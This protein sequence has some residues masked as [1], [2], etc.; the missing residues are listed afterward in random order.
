M[1][2]VK[3]IL[4][5]GEARIRFKSGEDRYDDA[6][7][8]TQVTLEEGIIPGG[9][10]AYLRCLQISAIN[11]DLETEIQLVKKILKLQYENFI[12]S[13][14][15]DPVK[16]VLIALQKVASIAVVFLTFECTITESMV[17]S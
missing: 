6:L 17:V 2:L 15:I 1:K 14:I 12:L 16:T 9:D 3:Q 7:K 8:S 5:D 11:S 4:Y 10:V 13:G